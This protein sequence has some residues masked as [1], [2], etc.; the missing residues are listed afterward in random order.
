MQVPLPGP[1]GAAPSASGGGPPRGG[2]RP[3][4]VT[5]AA[6]SSAVTL[7]Q[8]H[9]TSRAVALRAVKEKGTRTALKPSRERRH[10]TV[11]ACRVRAVSPPPHR[12]S[13]KVCPFSKPNLETR[14]GELSGG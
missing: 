5:L 1:R 4:G 12:P 11:C 13:K 9:V 10:T 7:A 8:V 6:T 14:G 2:A 3:G